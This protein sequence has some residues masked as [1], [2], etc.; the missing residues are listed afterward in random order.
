MCFKLVIYQRC[1]KTYGQ[2]NIKKK[3]IEYGRGQNSVF[4]HHRVITDFD[5]N[6]SDGVGC[7]VCIG[8]H[9]IITHGFSKHTTNWITPWP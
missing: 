8:M 9:I 2:Q 3:K 4:V 5:Q 7:V 6:F 1:T